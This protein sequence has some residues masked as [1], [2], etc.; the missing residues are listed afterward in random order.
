MFRTD[1]NEAGN[2]FP[3]I[4][5]AKEAGVLETLLTETNKI[6]RGLYQINIVSSGV[7]PITEADLNSAAA[8]GA[9]IFGF[10]VSCPQVIEA[11]VQSA[12]IL[13]RLHK[14]IYK[15][16]DDIADLAHDVKLAESK[17][18]GEGK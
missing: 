7:G 11:R 10:D 3:I 15:F 5:K 13:V 4:I 6:I 8:T 17:Q 14:L 9:T 18:R 2:Y 12:G 1:S 16:T